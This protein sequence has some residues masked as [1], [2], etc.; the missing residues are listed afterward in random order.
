MKH[1]MWY[2]DRWWARISKFL[3]QLKESIF[4]LFLDIDRQFSLC[5][6][7]LSIA[8]ILTSFINI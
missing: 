1:Y 5:T 7:K 8:L 3:L 4:D 6:E 2:V